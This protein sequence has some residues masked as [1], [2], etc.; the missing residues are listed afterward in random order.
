MLSY[1]ARI[2]A[3]MIASLGLAISAMA[4]DNYPSR[5]ITMVVPYAAGGPSDS[6][7]RLVAES[8]SNTL[9]VSSQ[10]TTSTLGS[11]ANR[12]VGIRPNGALT[13]VPI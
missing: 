1:V 4:Q 13:T 9:L 12:R 8:M 3:W 6:I 5:Q 10:G 11:L 2:A 7:A